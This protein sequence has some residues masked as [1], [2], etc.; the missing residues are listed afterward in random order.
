MRPPTPPP[1]PK[2]PN[3]LEL[4]PPAGAA[5][6]PPP[7]W[8]PM[9]R[10]RPRPMPKPLL[11]SML[12]SEGPKRVPPARQVSPPRP[13]E[14]ERHGSSISSIDQIR[15]AHPRKVCLPRKISRAWH[16]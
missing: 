2:A 5:P 8:P 4:G 9:P 6:M 12:G 15:V 3:Q 13:V 1:A 10:P 7:W 11:P 16:E 14:G